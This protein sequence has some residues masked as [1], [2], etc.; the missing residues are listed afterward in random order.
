MARRN[1][2]PPRGRGPQQVSPPSPEPAPAARPPETL[3]PGPGRVIAQAQSVGRI[4]GVY[5]PTDDQHAAKEE[6]KSRL[7]RVAV[8]QAA[9]HDRAIPNI[10]GVGLGLKFV[11]GRPTGQVVVK[12][13]VVRKL[14]ASQVPA[15]SLIPEQVNGVATD[16]DQFGLIAAHAAGRVRRPVPCGSDIGP[17]GDSGTLGCLVIANNKLCILSNNHVL[18][19]P[20]DGRPGD[21]IFQPGGAFSSPRDPADLIGQLET[22]VPIDFGPGADNRVDAA[23]AL[24][25][26]DA[27]YNLVDPTLAGGVVLAEDLLEPALGMNVHKVGMRTDHTFGQV[28]AAHVDNVPV[29]YEGKGTANFN[30]QVVIQGQGGDFSRPGD[31]GSL[32]LTTGTNQPVA[33]LMAGGAG[34]TIASPIAAVGQALGIERYVGKK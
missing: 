10:V 15:H 31:S 13:L 22:F 18:A 29:A 26:W 7:A 28:I 14:P 6:I 5:H 3:Q 9:G 32:I 33:L 24:T 4:P 30:G 1:P 19:G 21:H 25:S 23:L 8:P 12:V 34:G 11:D 27:A 2:R 20:N 17:R 16:V